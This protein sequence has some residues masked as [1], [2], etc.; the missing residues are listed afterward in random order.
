MD[1]KF[2]LAHLGILSIFATN[3]IGIIYFLTPIG[4]I[5]LLIATTSFRKTN[6]IAFLFLLIFL[7][8][9]WFMRIIIDPSLPYQY[10]FS[11]YLL[12][13]VI[14]YGL[15]IIAIYL[16]SMYQNQNKKLYIHLATGSILL[17]ITFSLYFSYFQLLGKEADGPSDAIHH[18]TQL[19]NPNDI[20]LLNGGHL[21][22]TLATPLNYYY[23]INTI[24]F[25]DFSQAN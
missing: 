15:L 9:V 22:R 20:V 8:I 23:H 2:N 12:G 4:F 17:I 5:I 16:G 18:I 10:Y 21:M 24:T 1:K 19:V 11:R 14:P 25:I 7:E 6:N 3:F 13:E